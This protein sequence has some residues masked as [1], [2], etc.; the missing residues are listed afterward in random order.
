MAELLLLQ[1]PQLLLLHLLL[2][3][4]LLLLKQPHLLEFGYLAAIASTAP[5]ALA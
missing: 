3:S 1:L 5:S 2:L 4:P